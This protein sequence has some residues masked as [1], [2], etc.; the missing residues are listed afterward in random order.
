MRRLIIII[1]YYCPIC[2]NVRRSSNRYQKI[3]SIVLIWIRREVKHQLSVVPNNIVRC[4]CVCYSYLRRVQIDIVPNISTNARSIKLQFF[5]P[6]FG[7]MDFHRTR[8]HFGMVP[9]FVVKLKFDRSNQLAYEWLQVGGGVDQLRSRV[10]VNPQCRSILSIKTIVFIT[11]RRILIVA[12]VVISLCLQKPQSPKHKKQ[13]EYY[14]S[15]FYEYVTLIY[16]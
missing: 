8:I 9:T 16:W 3:T 5:L 14:S 15:H 13:T 6:H 1:R 12:Y 2:I 11:R 4:K 10:V 7:D